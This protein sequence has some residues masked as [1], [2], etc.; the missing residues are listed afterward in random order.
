M[1]NELS[2][3]TRA[4]GQV[5]LDRWP[6][7]LIIVDDSVRPMIMNS[8]ARDAL[9]RGL[10]LGGEALRKAV[11]AATSPTVSWLSGATVVSLDLDRTSVAALVLPVPVSVDPLLGKRGLAF[12]AFG[13]DERTPPRD[14]LAVMYGFTKREGDLAC[15]LLKGQNVAEAAR[16]LGMTLSTA[17]T[18]LQHLLEKTGTTRQGE[19]LRL[20]LGSVP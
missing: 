2:R 3:A 13:G 17:R 11:T 7:S 8:L 20:L 14:L 18:H 6:Y 10:R 5:I 9:A 12:V 15:V 1:D 16:S 4:A 19:L